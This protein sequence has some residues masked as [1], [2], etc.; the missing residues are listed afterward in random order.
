[1]A[2]TPAKSATSQVW[3]P[4]PGVAW[5]TLAV[6]LAAT[7][8]VWHLMSNSSERTAQADFQSLA[9]EVHGA[10]TQRMLAYE[11]VL[12]GGIGL[13]AAV[14]HVTR[15]QWKTY[16][17]SLRLEESFPGI[18][19]VGYAELVA[20]KDLAAHIAGVRSE[21][22]PDYVVKPAGK[23]D[24]YTAI[25]YLEP[26][27]LRNRQAFGYDMFSQ[28]T[29]QAA[30]IEA[31]DTG[32]A[33]VS[34]KVILKQEITKDVQAGFLM[35]LPRY[36]AGAPVATLAERRAALMGYVYS[37]FRMNDLMTGILGAEK[38]DLSLAI[39]DGSEAQ[40][41]MLMYSDF[42]PHQSLFRSERQLDIQGH[43]WTLVVG[44]TPEFEARFSRERPLL[45]AQSGL[46]ISFLFTALVWALST[47]RSRAL[48]LAKTMTFTVREREGFIRAVVDNAADGI[49][50]MDGEGVLLSVNQAAQRIFGYDAQELQGQSVDTLMP[51]LKLTGKKALPLAG[52]DIR[53]QAK[54]RRRDGR[55]LDLGVRLSEIEQGGKRIYVAVVR[56]V[57]EQRQAEE[58]LRR[59]EER[60]DLAIRGANDGLWDWDLGTEKVY[61]SP[62]WKTMVGCSEHQIGDLW[63]EW[64]SRVHPDDLDDTMAKLNAHL[65]GETPQ[66]RAE[67][68]LQHRDGHYLWVLD[69]GVATRDPKG[70][71]YRM[72]GILSDITER[73]VV[74]KLKSEFVSTVSHELRTP[75]TSIR[76]SLGLMAGGA[77]GALPEQAAA[78]VDIASRNAERLLT[79]INDL[80]DMEKIQSGKLDFHW[81]RRNVTDLVRQALEAHRGYGE[82]FGVSFVLADGTVDAVARVDSDRLA[83]GVGQS[84]VQCRQ[85]FSSGQHG[86]G[87]RD[88]G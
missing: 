26:F 1:M 70:K 64:R 7:G 72:V 10:V 11:Q 27:N 2:Q 66:Y 60:L 17:D 42:G 47:H 35:Y 16:V 83:Q 69:R 25:I 46:I 63:E 34:G 22:F 15:S 61:F 39:Y 6:C 86:G 8:V 80:L 75:L 77:A 18:Q 57:T 23:R 65:D 36:R 59:S 40:P 20:P 33:S 79:L 45:V 55:P 13:F 24:V 31:R 54:G 85:I 3:Y 21:G 43:T 9:A 76:G 30:M 37:P 81:E 56:D 49:L 5:F 14:G 12:R 51:E 84:I 32:R 50:T 29:R 68:R 82:Q 44:S 67:Y 87:G 38:K 28:P 74:E 53:I 4:I 58:N 62:Q 19:G 48:A 73:K 71:V 41:D 78:L 52:D 88:K